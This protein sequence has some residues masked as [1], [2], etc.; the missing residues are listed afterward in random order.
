[1]PLACRYVLAG[2]AGSPNCSP[3]GPFA[4]KC[5]CFTSIGLEQTNLAICLISGGQN[6]VP[7]VFLL[8]AGWL[9]F[10]LVKIQKS[11]EPCNVRP[12]RQCGQLWAHGASSEACKGFRARNLSDMS[13]Q[14]SNLQ[15]TLVL[16]P[17][18]R[19]PWR[20]FHHILTS[21]ISGASARRIFNASDLHLA[22]SLLGLGTTSGSA[23]PYAKLGKTVLLTGQ[24]QECSC[25]KT[26]RE[27]HAC[28]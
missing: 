19:T 13:L 21:K 26:S 5:W 12:C 7:L 1:M 20:S 16:M 11:C 22:D 17:C 14:C 3:K 9:K 15:P 28:A 25:L 4:C 18:W 6:V 27:L 23:A 10:A 8:N 2:S 24:S